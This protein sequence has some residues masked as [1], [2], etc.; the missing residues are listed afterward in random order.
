[1]TRPGTTKCQATD[2]RKSFTAEQI[3][4]GALQESPG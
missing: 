2:R 1:V 3:A 4:A